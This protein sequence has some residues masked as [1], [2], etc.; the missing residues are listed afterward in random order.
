M[1]LFR[2]RVTTLRGEEVVPNLY[3]SARTV[4][5]CKVAGSFVRSAFSRSLKALGRSKR[6]G[7]LFKFRLE[8]VLGGC[9]TGNHAPLILRDLV[10]TSPRFAV[11]LRAKRRVIWFLA[12]IDLRL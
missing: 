5:R 9:A 1:R 12:L 11:C 4:Q 3:F 2:A 8:I 10:P 7:L 6:R